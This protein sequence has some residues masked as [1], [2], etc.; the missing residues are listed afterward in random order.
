[1]GKRN[2][3]GDSRGGDDRRR[4]GRRENR[5]TIEALVDDNGVLEWFFLEEDEDECSSSANADSPNEVTIEA[6]ED[7]EG[8]KRGG[9]RRGPKPP[10]RDAMEEAC[11]DEDPAD[12]N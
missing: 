8:R 2:R 5:E 7:R 12:E 9:G 4:P 11:A 10:F 1:M 6:R 3:G